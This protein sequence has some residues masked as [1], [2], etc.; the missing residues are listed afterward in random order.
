VIN[1]TGT[2]VTR[3]TT[4][5]YIA[6][7]WNSAKASRFWVLLAL[8]SVIAAAGVV[9]DSTATVIGAMI[10]APLMTPILGTALAVVMA[11]R[12]H[13]TRSIALVLSGALAV[14]AISFVIGVFTAPLDSYQ[15]NSQVLGR[16]SPGLIDLL[17]A[18]ATGMVG[19]FALVRADIA[20]TLPGVAIA[21]SLVPPLAVVGL[22]LEVQ[23]YG[24]AAGA[25]LLFATNI[26][27]IVATGTLVLLLYRV[28]EAA[29]Q[30]GLPVGALTGRTLAVVGGGVL[31]VSVPLAAGS[32]SVYRD[33]LLAFQA[34][35]ITQE[36]ASEAGW[37]ATTVDASK[38]VILVVALGA[39]PDADPRGLRAAL[40]EGGLEES[41]LRIRLVV[42]GIRDCPAG[43][44]VCS[45]PNTEGDS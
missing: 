41:D 16:V 29:Q 39:P 20:D 33:E 44:R 30:A 45:V 34:A 22:L 19:A 11:D 4:A 12:V 36:W 38:G 21:I 18:L 25:A 24:D 6:P 9:S 7:P 5:V 28:R 8:S 43:E 17:A 13:M 23:R 42:G 2:E 10:V 15:S 35:P 32:Y 40:D 14:V 37:Q 1:V 3:M 27:A 31:L 26:A